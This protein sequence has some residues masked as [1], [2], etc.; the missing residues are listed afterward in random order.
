MGRF[1]KDQIHFLILKTHS[2][3]GLIPVGAFLVIHLT[4]NSLRTVGVWQYQL[5]IDLINNLPF[6]I[7]IEIGFIYVPLLFH[8]L[9]GFYIYRGGKRNTAVYRYPRNYL[10]TL[11]RLSGAVVFAFLIYHMGTTVAPKLLYDKGGFEA[12]PYLISIMNTEFESWLGR[13]IYFIGISAAA[14]HFANGLW[15]FCISWGILLG[16]NAQRTMGYA[17]LLVGVV[18]FV[19]GMATVAEFSLNPIDVQ[20]TRPGSL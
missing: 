10:Y 12:A 7:W 6:L 9:V 19:M 17:F 1:N 16:K 13:I 4:V 8:S 3:T 20:P 11:Q 18:L 2:L 14:F 5:S 15:G